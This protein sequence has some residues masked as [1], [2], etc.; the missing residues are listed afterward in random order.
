[1][2]TIVLLKLAGISN[3]MLIVP[4]IYYCWSDYWCT[5]LYTGPTCTLQS[6]ESGR[7]K[8][9]HSGLQQHQQFYNKQIHDLSVIMK[10]YSVI[11]FRGFIY[12]V[13]TQYYPIAPLRNK[14]NLLHNKQYPPFFF[15][16]SQTH[17]ILS[18]KQKK[19]SVEAS[20]T[21]TNSPVFLSLMKSLKCFPHLL[22]LTLQESHCIVRQ[23]NKS[24][25]II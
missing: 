2:V 20:S 18:S 6:F 10:M 22:S 4:I 11:I 1:M 3:R 25:G 12:C 15:L 9:G 13:N 16:P 7:L 19:P 21:N 17:Q 5:Y 8:C 23:L 14:I 24:H